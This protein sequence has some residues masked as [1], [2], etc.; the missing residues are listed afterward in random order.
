M[1]AA[2]NFVYGDDDGERHDFVV[3]GEIPDEIVEDLPNHLVLEKLA[4]ADPNELTRDQL[5]VLAGL[6]GEEEAE[7]NAVQF[8]ESLREFNT[9]A[10]LVDWANETMGM[11][12]AVD[13]GNREELEEMVLAFAGPDEEEEE[14]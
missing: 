13:D 11:E 10:S 5:M 8:L 3:G 7:F 6:K 4:Q 14:D 1:K 2:R 9:K 12:L